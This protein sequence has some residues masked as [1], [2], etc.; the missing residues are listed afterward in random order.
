MYIAV[1]VLYKPLL[2]GRNWA[3]ITELPSP[4]IGGSEYSAGAVLA[5]AR[6]MRVRKRRE[7]EAREAARQA[8]MGQFWRKH[9]LAVENQSDKDVLVVVATQ[10]PAR[11]VNID[12]ISCAGAVGGKLFLG[13]KG[14]FDLIPPVVSPAFGADKLVGE[15]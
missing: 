7:Q 4:A 15:R 8:A 9:T 10:E 6:E 3:A 1:R 11:F 2:Y 5:V 13:K 14:L 12:A